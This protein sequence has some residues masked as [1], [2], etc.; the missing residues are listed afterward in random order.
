MR[1][2]K[3]HP[4]LR[5]LNSYL[6]DASQPSNISYLWNFGSLLAFC[7][8][9]Q[10]VTGVT[11]AM[12]FNANIYD[13]FNSIEHIMRDVNNGWLIRYLHANTASAFFFLVYLHIGRG[14][15]YGS[16]KAPRALVWVIGTIILI[17]IIA[18]GFL[19]YVL[20]YGQMS[21]WGATVITNL[22]SAIPW[23]G[24]DIVE[25]IWGGFSVNNATLN[26]FF[27][28]HYVLPFVLA[29]LVLLHLIALHEKAGSGN[30]LGI[31]NY[32]DRLTFSPYFIF[33]DLIT[34]FI[35]IFVLS[36]LVFFSPNLLGDSEN[37]VM[38][39]PMQTPP[40][41]VPEWYLLP[42][43]AILRSIPN[44]LLG[45]I[46]MFSALLIILSLIF[47]DL[48]KFRGFQYRPLSKIAFYSFV[49][50]FLSLMVLGARHVESPYIEFG[51]ISTLLYFLYFLLFIPV[52]SYIENDIVKLNIRN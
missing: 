44:K 5:L 22:M 25:F 12:H 14:I 21:L 6:I 11:L 9:I 29:V 50:I 37:Y 20:P 46:A 49:A 16:Y 18:T 48:N 40:A 27:S 13:A 30:P 34:I 24:V 38:A 43:Y 47:L 4:I 10:I 51:Q 15:Y 42:Y 17:M 33:K 1:I 31:G 41:I 45:V 7:L 32:V 36:S 19:G 2:L 3:N 52:I 23:V 8:G 26:R 35:F 28:L 39:N